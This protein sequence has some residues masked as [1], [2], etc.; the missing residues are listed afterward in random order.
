MC[1][2]V[3]NK[4]IIKM[5]LAT[6]LYPSF[7]HYIAF[8]SEEVLS[9]M[10]QEKNMYRSSTVYKQKQFWT[11]TVDINV[12]GQQVMDLFTGG[13]VIMDYGLVFWPEAKLNRFDD[14]FVS[15]KY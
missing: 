11:N 7:I 5:L 10:I 15:Y 6:N 1:V 3:I 9:C 2:F 8:S 13:N 12:R 4:S 14:R